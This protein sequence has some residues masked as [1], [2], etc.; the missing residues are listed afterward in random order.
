[1]RLSLSFIHLI[2]I[3]LLN[4]YVKRYLFKIRKNLKSNVKCVKNINTVANS[5]FE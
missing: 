5:D 2:I 4:F 1:M 3:Y